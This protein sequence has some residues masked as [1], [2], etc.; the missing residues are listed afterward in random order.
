[1]T[2]WTQWMDFLFRVD[3]FLKLRI[4]NLRIPLLILQSRISGQKMLLNHPYLQK[5]QTPPT[6]NLRTLA[7]NLLKPVMLQMGHHNMQ[8]LLKTISLNLIQ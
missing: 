1:M 4:L 7:H 8:S 2:Y 6:R 3:L 5:V